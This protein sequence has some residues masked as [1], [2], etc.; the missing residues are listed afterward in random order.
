[1]LRTYFDLRE[2]PLERIVVLISQA[3]GAKA[4]IASN[5]AVWKVIELINA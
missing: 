1:M 2:L 4:S 3:E 5:N